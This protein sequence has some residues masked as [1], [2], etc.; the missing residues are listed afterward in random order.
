MEE[1]IKYLQGPIA[2]MSTNIRS[3]RFSINFRTAIIGFIVATGIAMG[4]FLM[5]LLS[6]LK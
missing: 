3:K 5:T 2:I 4:V 6:H 1:D